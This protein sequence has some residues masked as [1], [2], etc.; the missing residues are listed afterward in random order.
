MTLQKKVFAPR[1]PHGAQFWKLRER[2]AGTL[3]LPIG[4]DKY[5]R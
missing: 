4:R 5:G 3:T 1:H 2:L